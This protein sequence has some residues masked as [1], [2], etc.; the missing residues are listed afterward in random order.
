MSPFTDSF[1]L[2][3]LRPARGRSCTV[4]MS[5]DVEQ[6]KTPLSTRLLLVLCVALGMLLGVGGYT[7][8][9]AEGLSYLSSDPR[10]CANCHIMQSQYDSW[11]KSSHHGTAACVDCHLPV[12]L[13][14]K[15]MAK[16]SNGYHH[17]KG[18]TFQDFKE[19]VRIKPGNAAVLQENCLRCHQDMV[20]ALVAG[21]TTD[22]DAVQCVHCH[23]GV[24]HGETAGLGP[25]RSLDAA[26]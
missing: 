13:P 26:P 11:Q 12:N 10:A 8:S 20:H 18:F 9:Y 4:N 6:T 5:S 3:W 7:F 22:R 2:E 1:G 16:A 17:S 25:S 19:P 21:A 23:Y 15:L 24:G 14:A